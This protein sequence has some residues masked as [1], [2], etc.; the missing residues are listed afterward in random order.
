MPA[1]PFRKRELAAIIGVVNS[2]PRHR[3]VSGEG[4]GEGIEMA[5]E[6]DPNW[7]GVD[8]A[9]SAVLR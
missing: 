8:R 2:P 4:T 5:A 1:K 7:K 9:V 3:T 6:I